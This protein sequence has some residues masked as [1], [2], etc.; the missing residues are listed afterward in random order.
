MDIYC[1]SSKLNSIFVLH[2][3]QDHCYPGAPCCDDCSNQ[4][5]ENIN[6]SEVLLEYFGISNSG[7]IQVQ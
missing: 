4:N 6:F 7:K 5:P 2:T 3:N 1:N